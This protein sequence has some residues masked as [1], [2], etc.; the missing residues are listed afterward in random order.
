MNDPGET[1]KH[2][3]RIARHEY[4]DNSKES[5]ECLEKKKR[6][7]EI[8]T[9]EGAGES[10]MQTLSR[11]KGWNEVM[12][13]EMRPKTKPL[14]DDKAL[15]TSNT[16]KPSEPIKEGIRSRYTRARIHP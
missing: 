9:P 3:S 6:R 14:R 4:H 10:P 7:L 11:H 8:H 13:L 5:R 15:T 1:T 16:L 2:R 12:S